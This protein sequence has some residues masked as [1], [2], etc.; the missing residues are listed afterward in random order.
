MEHFEIQG[1]KPAIN[2]SLQTF[3]CFISKTEEEG[4]H[5]LHVLYASAVG[6]IMY[7]MAC[8]RL[9]ISNANIMVSRYIY[10]PLEKSIGK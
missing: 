5:M 10:I 4:V 1:W 7:T 2:N 3:E 6:N 9:D 8:T